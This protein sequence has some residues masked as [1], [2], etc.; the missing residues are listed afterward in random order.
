VFAVYTI[1]IVDH[2]SLKNM[3]EANWMNTGKHMQV[4]FLFLIA[5]TLLGFPAVNGYFG[6]R[7]LAANGSV[8]VENDEPSGGQVIVHDPY[9][10]LNR[11]MFTVNDKAY[12]WIFKPVGT[13][14]AAYFPPGFRA[15]VRNGFHNMLFPSR[16]VNCTLQGKM[17]KAGA[18]TVRFLI[19]STIGVGGLFDVAEHE[20]SIHSYEEDFGLTLAHFGAGTG[21]FMMVP[22]IGPS[23]PRDLFGYVV[24]SFMD[25]MYYIPAA[26]WVSPTVKAGK[27]VN[28]GSLK[29]GEY[30]DFKKSALDPYIAMRDAYVQ[31]RQKE[32]KK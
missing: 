29:I 22:V 21:P 18:E 19:N 16:F 20:F 3:E 7:L 15:A 13:I 30:E 9:E 31:H 10:K 32:M 25:P 11:V 17:D 1:T 2:C 4:V 6:N 27:I 14:Y 24:D 26:V 12:F 23:N 8:A 28:N 5:F